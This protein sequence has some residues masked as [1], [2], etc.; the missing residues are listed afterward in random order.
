[1]D[2]LTIV[3]AVSNGAFA[4]ICGA[5]GLRLL[6]LARRT[7]RT[8]EFL[9]GAGFG[10][11]VIGVPCLA[12]SGLGRAAAG[13]VS[14]PVLGFGFTLLGVGMI[15]LITF[16]WQ[17][18]RPGSRWAAALAVGLAVAVAI[19]LVGCVRAVAVAPAEQASQAALRTWAIWL[20]VPLMVGFAWSSVESLH[21]Y[22][23][24]RRRMALDMG[25]P[26]VTNRFLL[27]AGA[28]LFSFLNA[29]VGTVLQA[30]GMGP[31]AS[32]LGAIVLATGGIVGAILMGLAFIPP[33]AY[34]NLVI[35]R[36][37]EAHASA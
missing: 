16:T 20:R 19:V 37:A 8:P 7:H 31:V 3:L 30:M 11:M 33:A 23:M 15:G 28:S 18:F 27:F 12:A 17:A 10:C 32:P 9:L 13:D 4:L 35:R 6:A 25:D 22:G 26:V 5:V 34:V 24:A 14:L 2:L 1:M 29:A 36:S 21:Q